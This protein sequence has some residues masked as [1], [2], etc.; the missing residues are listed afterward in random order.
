MSGDPLDEYDTLGKRDEHEIT[1]AS[2]DRS[3]P[4][5]TMPR[6]YELSSGGLW[7]A[8]ADDGKGRSPKALWLASEFEITA[9]ARDSDGEDWSL[10]IEF[11][12]RD[13]RH[14]REIIGRDELAG[15]TVEVRRRL[16]RRGLILNSTALGRERLQVFL[17]GVRTL[18]RAR[19]VYA[20][21]W[22]G[23]NYVLPHLTI[24]ASAAETVLFRGRSGGANHAQAGTYE[25]WR[26][27]VA[28]LM[29]GNASGVF[30]LS[31]AFAAPLLRELGGEGGG[32]HF[33]GKSSKGKSTLQR[34][35]GS[36]RTTPWTRWRSRT[37]T[38][39]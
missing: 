38:G 33:R 29:A 18:A 11:R 1:L 3:K 19:L 34:V 2:D 14:K 31:T 5:V 37:M 16:L 9:E 8:P 27:D 15:E 39:S 30:A 13:G 25:A 26:A 28:A 17:S 36:T 4:D 23:D 12:D 10:V 35:A 21:G 7:W 6:G 22:Q 32:F 20:A 24:G